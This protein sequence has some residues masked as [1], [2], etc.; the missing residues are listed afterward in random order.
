MHLA[1]RVSIMFRTGVLVAA[2][3]VATLASANASI[4]FGTGNLGGPHENVQYNNANPGG[5]TLITETNQDTSV[6]F[7]G[8]ENLQSFGGGQARISGTDGNIHICSGN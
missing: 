3:T 7:T 5:M 8:L 1:K 2:M 4:V 6:T